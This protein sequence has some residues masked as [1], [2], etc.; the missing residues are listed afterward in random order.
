MVDQYIANA[1]IIGHLYYLYNIIVINGNYQY[2]PF[3]D[4]W[5]YIYSILFFQITDVIIGWHLYLFSENEE[6]SIKPIL[7]HPIFFYSFTSVLYFEW[8]DQP[9]ETH[10][11]HFSLS[12]ACVL[13]H[14]HSI[15]PTSSL[16]LQ[17]DFCVILW[18]HIH[19]LHTHTHRE[20]NPHSF[21]HLHMYLFMCHASWHT[22]C[23]N[24]PFLKSF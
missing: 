17:N 8:M 7:I 18:W 9:L 14:P 16:I 23:S 10:S 5:S 24:L 2:W 1:G 12:E 21:I 15:K 4:H 3:V 19:H 13:F 22:L 20:K 6:F 11:S